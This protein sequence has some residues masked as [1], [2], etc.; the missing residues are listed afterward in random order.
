MQLV[1]TE[2]TDETNIPV[3]KSNQ[4]Y[5]WCEEAINAVK[6][7]P[8]SYELWIETANEKLNEIDN[9]DIDLVEEDKKTKITITRKDGTTKE[10]IIAGGDKGVSSYSQLEDLP[11]I[12]GVELIG[13]MTTDEL[14]IEGAIIINSDEEEEVVKSKILSAINEEK[15]VVKPLFFEGDGDLLRFKQTNKTPEGIKFIFGNEWLEE[16]EERK[17]LNVYDIYITLPEDITQPLIW[18]GNGTEISDTLYMETYVENYF[19]ENKETLVGP[20]GE[21]GPQG[22]PGENG[23]T[24]VKGV[25]YFDGEPGKDGEPGQPGEQGIQGEP[26]YAPVKGTDYW[27]EEDKSEI[28]TYI[29]NSID[30][31][32][33]SVLEADY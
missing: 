15:N 25:D 30:E 1:I 12:N 28:E 13:N 32:I 11:T 10:T 6:E 18:G 26:G 8:D 21:Q 27:T 17:Y 29:N 19:N 20:Q 4:F 14:K 23:Y 24:P 9:L 33:T 3:F 22:I 31:K 2:G 5:L 16:Y 7:A